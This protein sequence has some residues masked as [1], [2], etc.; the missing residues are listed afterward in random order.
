MS[1]PLQYTAGSWPTLGAGGLVAMLG[2]AVED[3]RVDR[4][5]ELAEG[6][7]SLDDLIDLL[8]RDGV[9][10]MPDFA[11]CERQD[12]ATWRI[13][14]RGSVEA[15]AD[16]E[17]IRPGQA[18]WLDQ[19]IRA[20]A[21]ELR[22]TQEP[23]GGRR[24]VL[25]DGLVLAAS[26]LVTA[27]E[28]L[29][30]SRD[31]PPA[32]REPERP[33]PGVTVA[34]DVVAPPTVTSVTV[35]QPAAPFGGV[36][37]LPPVTPE[38]DAG[39]PPAVSADPEDDPGQMAPVP[40][41]A[42]GSWSAPCLEEEGD[43]G[44]AQYDFDFGLTTT[45]AALELEQ[46]LREGG[47]LP[48]APRDA[49]AVPGVRT[50]VGAPASSAGSPATAAAPAESPASPAV[51]PGDSFI[52]TVPWATDAAAGPTPVSGRLTG[53]VGVHD[54]TSD[55]TAVTASDT[56]LGRTV[57]RA[58][59]M[60]QGGPEAHT[61][62]A[63]RCAKGHLTQAAAPTCRVC[64]GAVSAQEHFL[65]PRPVLGVLRLSTG[66]EVR[67]DRA[68]ILGRNPFVPADYSGEQPNLVAVIDPSLSVS[69][70][71]LE[72]TLNFWQVLVRDLTS[73]N[74]TQ[75][76]LPG[77]APQALRPGEFVPLPPGGALLLGG[78]VRA[79]FEVTP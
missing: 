77:Q 35:S 14:L 43:T 13:L 26:V 60:A 10:A 24:L 63:A 73:L 61:V 59:L 44:L 23:G 68:A 30:P 20:A 45:R 5:L 66:T 64:G 3:P 1:A 76:V 25:R 70:Q 16:G 50:A 49:H 55:H 38:P 74:G 19:T 72:V 69:S 53:A 62:W 40:S 41:P 65:A 37:P 54:G 18:P 22:P 21:V 17:S 33:A 15:V 9:R 71:H 57:S 2:V 8:V 11:L 31:E 51:G 28:T 6:V 12:A 39:E 29:D 78:Q 42:V 46:S 36:V 75:L 7:L 58:Q 34:S 4:L 27:S 52:T 47:S 32:P 56:A 67:L 79:T 48:A